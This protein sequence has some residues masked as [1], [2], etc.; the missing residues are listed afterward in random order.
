MRTSHPNRLD[1]TVADDHDERSQTESVREKK[2][3][4]LEIPK[5]REREQDRDSYTEEEEEEKRR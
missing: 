1:E 4:T 3:Y 2:E 5:D